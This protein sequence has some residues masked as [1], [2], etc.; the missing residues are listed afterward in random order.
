M[1]SEGRRDTTFEAPSGPAAPSGPRDVG[2]V[3]DASKAV[4][5]SAMDTQ[6]QPAGSKYAYRGSHARMASVTQPLQI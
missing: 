1:A 5:A 3:T 2:V 6:P 4:Q